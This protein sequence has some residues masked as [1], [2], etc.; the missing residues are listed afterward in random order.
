MTTRSWLLLY[1][2]WELRFLRHT[3]CFYVISLTQN[4]NFLMWVLFQFHI[5]V[6]FTKV[7]YFGIPQYQKTVIK[8]I[9]LIFKLQS[10][11]QERNLNKLILM[12]KIE[13]YELIPIIAYFFV[14]P[15]SLSL[16]HH[17]PSKSWLWHFVK[18]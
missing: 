4:M 12:C 11:V 3:V 15:R 5:T 6:C 2:F 10:R 7:T 8:K 16:T 14:N 1:T 13:Q 18:T 9:T 17:I